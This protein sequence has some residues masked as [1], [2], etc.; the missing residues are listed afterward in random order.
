MNALA[1]RPSSS[2]IVVGGAFTSAGSLPCSAVCVYDSGASQ[3]LRPGNTDLEGEVSQIV[4]TDAN[5][6]VVVGNISFGGN[7]TFV[8]TYSFSTSTWSSV[9]MGLTGPVETIL[10]QTSTEWFL[11]G[12]N[13]TGVY[14]GLWNGQQYQDLSTFPY[15]S[16][17]TIVNV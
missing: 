2:Q 8:G 4:F 5:T 12:E 10:V 6:A 13:S 1:A 16:L 17:W 14:F 9:N 3:W 11:A 7:Q 15:T